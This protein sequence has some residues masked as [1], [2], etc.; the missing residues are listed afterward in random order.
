MKKLFL[1][2][3]AGLV[4]GGLIGGV[5]AWWF[6]RSS[7]PNLLQEQPQTEKKPEPG[8]H[9]TK[10]QQ[11]AAGLIISK[12]QPAEQ[13]PEIK[14]FG[15]VLDASSLA[16]LQAEIEI[17]DSAA[18]ASTKE[19]ERLKSL[20]ENAAARAL[21]TAQAAMI[22]DRAASQ[23]A[24]ARLV[25]G[26]GKA[27]SERADLSALTQSLLSQDAALARVDLPAGERL[28]GSPAAVR[29]AP[30]SDPTAWLVAEVLGPA[31]ATDPQSQ[32]QAFLIL[33]RDH[34]PAPGAALTVRL[35]A[36]T[37]TQKGFVLPGRA[38]IQHESGLFVYVQTADEAFVRKPVEV[39]TREGED[40]FIK[41]G[42]DANDRVV[43]TGGQQ[44]LS[45]EFKDSG[46]E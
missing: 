40:V 23:A 32:G 45:E 44:L 26:W 24:R 20:G 2:T 36:S 33:I 21:E 42:I 25:A 35:T 43:V 3:I 41:S 27:L 10:D 7:R 15:R 38:V 6:L 30:V 18:A 4:I 11:S 28:Q 8:V 37:E 14:G 22:R 17:A 31:T 12:P 34:P 29:V 1:G 9:L 19:W 13:A 16:T 5:S 46:E 39:S